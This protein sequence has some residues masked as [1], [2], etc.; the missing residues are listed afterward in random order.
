MQRYVIVDRIKCP[1][2]KNIFSNAFGPIF[3][4]SIYKYRPFFSTTFPVQYCSL[5]DQAYQFLLYDC[6]TY[7]SIWSHLICVLLCSII[8]H[9]GIFHTSSVSQFSCLFNRISC[10]CS[11]SFFPSD[12]R[13]VFIFS[14][15]IHYV[16]KILMKLDHTRP[17]QYSVSDYYYYIGV[18]H[19]FLRHKRVFQIFEKCVEPYLWA[20]SY[21]NIEAS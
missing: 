17:C 1:D 5:P 15:L 12:I 8:E 18:H 14:L 3:Y 2:E 13:P 4:S 11:I 7:I 10:F 20:I 9:N 16:N 19:L 6:F 21:L